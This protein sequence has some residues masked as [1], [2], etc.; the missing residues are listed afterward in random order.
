MGLS[1]VLPYVRIPPPAITLLAPVNSVEIVS[2]KITPDSYIVNKK[3]KKII[4]KIRQKKKQILLDKDILKLS[5]IIIKIEKHF[6]FPC[7]IEWAFEKG[8]IFIVQSRPITTL[9]NKFK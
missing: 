9:K 8:K 6:K 7:D 4:S 5:D 1:F 3:T 2:G